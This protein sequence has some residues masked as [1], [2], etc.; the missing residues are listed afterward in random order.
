[1]LKPVFSLHFQKQRQEQRM[2]PAQIQR[3]AR[4]IEQ[5][6]R[7][8]PIHIFFLAHEGISQPQVWEEW[9]QLSKTVPGIRVY[10][11]VLTTPT[12]LQAQPFCAQYAMED[13]TIGPTRW[14]SFSIVAEMIKGFQAIEQQYRRRDGKGI[15][16]LT[17]GTDIPVR[18]PSNL[19]HLTLDNDDI[20]RHVIG[21]EN[22][23]IPYVHSQWMGIRFSSVAR[24][25]AKIDM[26]IL[27]VECMEVIHQ[28]LLKTGNTYH[29]DEFFYSIIR[30][31]PPSRSSYLHMNCGLPKHIS[32]P[33]YWTSLATPQFVSHFTLVPPRPYNKVTLAQILFELKA[34]FQQ[35][36]QV[37]SEKYKTVFFFRKISPSVVFPAGF[38]V[39]YLWN[40]D[41]QY[42]HVPPVFRPLLDHV[43]FEYFL[44]PRD[45]QYEPG[46]DIHPLLLKSMPEAWEKEETPLWNSI[47]EKMDA[48]SRQRQHAWKWLHRGAYSHAKQQKAKRVNYIQRLLSDA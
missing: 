44:D 1:M 48:L 30:P 11:H 31:I 43:N 8:Y 36:A 45:P 20:V 26:F 3:I 15:I 40:D 28:S 24:Y 16:L 10:Y 41:I 2:D 29:P 18:H 23:Q 13:M 35:A 6:E 37:N 39:D 33:A 17:S 4:A 27:F 25:F 19:I 21:P 9:R 47:D 46:D 22:S 12:I 38:F 5:E 14:G 32:I 7:R 42:N 34:L